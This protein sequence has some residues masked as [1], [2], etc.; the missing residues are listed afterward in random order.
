MQAGGR[1]YLRRIAIASVV[2]TILIIG[3]RVLLRSIDDTRLRPLVSVLPILPVLF[4]FFALIQ[5]VRE[6]DELQRKIQLDAMVF[7]LGLTGVITFTLGLL[8]GVGVPSLSMTWV[9]PLSIAL[10]G[11]G[12]ALASRRYQ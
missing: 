1:V 7:S 11:I 8:E 3:T 12:L 10:W 6:M 5:F 9:L 4:G 2:Y